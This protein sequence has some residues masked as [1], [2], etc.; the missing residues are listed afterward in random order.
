MF[1]TR[2]DVCYWYSPTYGTPDYFN[3]NASSQ[4]T[5]PTSSITAS[6]SSITSTQADHNYYTGTGGYC[7]IFATTENTTNKREYIQ[8]QLKQ[9]LTSGQKYYGVFYA[10]LRDYSSRSVNQLGMYVSQTGP[11]QNNELVFSSSLTP[12][13][14]TGGGSNLSSTTNWVR[15]EGCFTAAGN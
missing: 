6:P 3:A 11:S 15:V 4:M 5:V 1:S 13:I 8:T 10:N 2:S 9:H 12:Q 7:G 14:S